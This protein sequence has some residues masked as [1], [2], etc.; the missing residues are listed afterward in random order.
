MSVE[1]ADNKICPAESLGL[2]SI[3]GKRGSL[4]PVN[5]LKNIYRALFNEFGK[6]HWWPGDT[7]EEIIIGAVLTQ[8]TNWGNVER[9]I[10]NLKVADALSF[11][12]LLRLLPNELSTLI[13]PSGYYNIKEKRLRSVVEY[14]MKRCGADFKRLQSIPTEQLRDELLSVHGVGRE[15]ADSILLYALGRAVFVIDAYT[16]RIG[17]RHGFLSDDDRYESARALFERTLERNI[18]LFNEYHALLVRLGK[19]FCRPKPLCG[20]CPLN[21]DGKFLIQKA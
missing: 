4:L 5:I 15:T 14:F 13:R 12:R 17:R 11:E 20:N 16:M 2:D 1:F 6:Q 21:K 7:T 3:V 18:P 9:A 19:E 8:N 10:K